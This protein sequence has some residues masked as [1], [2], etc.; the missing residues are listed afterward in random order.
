[1]KKPRFQTIESKARAVFRSGNQN[2]RIKILSNERDLKTVSEEP[3][4]AEAILADPLP[5][6]GIVDIDEHVLVGMTR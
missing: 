1:M 3:K 4:S 6:G 2:R 5:I